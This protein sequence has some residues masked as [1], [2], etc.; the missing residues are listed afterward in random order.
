MPNS[1]SPYRNGRLM[2]GKEHPNVPFH[3]LLCFYLEPVVCV[4]S[5]Y[6]R[7]LLTAVQCLEESGRAL[8]TCMNSHIFHLAFTIGIRGFCLKLSICQRRAG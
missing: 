3:T 6:H 5:P 8:W 7:H 2:I 4:R 1:Q